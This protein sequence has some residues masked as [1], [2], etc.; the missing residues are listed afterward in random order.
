MK[1]TLVF[2]LMV[3]GFVGTLSAADLFTG[4]WKLNVAKSTFTP[5]MELKANSVVIAEKGAD[6]AISGT[7]SDSAGKAVSVKYTFPMKGGVGAPL[8]K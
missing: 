1:K 4:T 7:G 3:L 8:G 2:A 6:L 5:G